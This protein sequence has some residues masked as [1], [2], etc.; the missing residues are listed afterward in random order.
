MSPVLGVLVT[1]A[2]VVVAVGIA[3]LVRRR[4]PSGGFFNDTQR[5]AGVFTVV[6]TAYAVLLAFTFLV[7]FQSFD[8]AKRAARA[9]ARAV[10]GLFDSAEVFPAA[11]RRAFGAELHCYARAVA[12]DEWPAMSR[13]EQSSEVE[14]SIQRLQKRIQRFPTDSLRR[15][16]ALDHLLT[17]FGD[18]GDARQDRIDESQHVIPPLLWVV[19]GIGLL[20]V[21]GYMLVWADRS[22]AWWVQAAMMAAV[23]AILVSSLLT[24]AFLDNPFEDASGSIKPTA[25]ERAQASLGATNTGG[26]CPPPRLH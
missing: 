18:R 22:E 5:A 3:M 19:L 23:M 1:L 10:T 26:R 24:I 6:G 25:M 8:S 7:A 21:F 12:Q 4:S 15:G 13:G 11:D 9:E 14:A 20:V 16:V 17:Q 2:A